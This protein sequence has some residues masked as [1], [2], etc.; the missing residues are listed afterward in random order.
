MPDRI[1]STASAS[2]D[3]G[4]MPDRTCSTASA[5]CDGDGM[6]DRTCSKASASHDGCGAVN[7]N[8]NN[9]VQSYQRDKKAVTYSKVHKARKVPCYSKNIARLNNLGNYYRES[10]MCE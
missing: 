8:S 4:G 1:C 5:S 7:S 3:G 6:P 9:M 2:C 10:C